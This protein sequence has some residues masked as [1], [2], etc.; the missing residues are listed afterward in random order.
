MSH[1]NPEKEENVDFE[2]L[3]HSFEKQPFAISL[4]QAKLLMSEL[5]GKGLLSKPLMDD[6]LWSVR[7][8]DN[9]MD[10]VLATKRYESCPNRRMVIWRAADSTTFAAVIWEKGSHTAIHNHSHFGLTRT[11]Q[12]SVTSIGFRKT[13]E[14]QLVCVGQVHFER[15]RVY[16]VPAS[17]SFIHSVANYGQEAA[18]ELH[19]YSPFKEEPSSKFEILDKTIDVVKVRDGDLIEYKLLEDPEQLQNRFE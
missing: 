9:F 19:F 2:T 13:E 6:I 3:W 5:H 16:H 10:I 1:S 7:V 17:D 18:L 14:N 12:G 15:N 8:P 4:N 11:L